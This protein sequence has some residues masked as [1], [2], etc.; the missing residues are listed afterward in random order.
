MIIRMQDGK[1][2]NISVRQIVTMVF[3]A[4][5]HFRSDYKSPGSMIDV[6]KLDSE[7]N[8]F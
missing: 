5:G 1:R 4:W 8:Y 6:A 7:Q 2:V 3:L